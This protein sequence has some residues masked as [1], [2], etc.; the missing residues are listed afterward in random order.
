MFWL[1][2]KILSLFEKPVVVSESARLA[3]ERDLLRLRRLRGGAPQQQQWEREDDE[4]RG[5]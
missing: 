5:F 2:S 4:H 1:L 3:A